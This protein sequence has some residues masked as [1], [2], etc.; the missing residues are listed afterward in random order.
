MP[1]LEKGAPEMLG[2]KRSATIGVTQPS[3]GISTR[4][5]ATYIVSAE[6]KTRSSEIPSGL[7]KSEKQPKLFW[8]VSLFLLL[9]CLPV[10][11]YV[12]SLRLPP[13][14][15][16]LLVSAVPCLLIWA[17]SKQVN[18]SA[19]DF[20]LIM[21]VVWASMAISIN[22]GFET[23]IELIGSVVLDTAGS[24]FLA[25]T[26]IS[27]VVRF[28]RMTRM[29]IG[30]V[31]IMA[32]FTAYES[33]TGTNLI[34]KMFQP[35]FN[36]FSYPVMDKRLS[37]FRARGPF[38]HP[39]LFG[40][41]ASTVFSFAM[42]IKSEKYTGFK[43]AFKTAMVGLAVFSSLSTGA[44]L[45]VILQIILLAWDKLTK[46]FAHRWRVFAVLLLCAYIF[47]DA[48]SNRNPFEVFISYLTFNQGNSYNRVLI[49]IYGTAEVWRHPVFGI[50]HGDWVRPYW[51][52]ISFDNFWL[53]RTMR[54]GLP[55]FFFLFSSVVLI[56]WKLAKLKPENDLT[57]QCRKSLLIM[58]AGLCVTMIT[59]DLWNATY[60]MFFFLLGSGD[61]L[62][63]SD[64]KRD[65]D[66]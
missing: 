65:A 3:T 54:Y 19:A 40:F 7:S 43:R 46:S 64:A 16:F 63:E 47:V 20:M 13:Y 56:A 2:K 32:C 50:G 60:A 44:F 26:L 1:P 18:R 31:M 25:K 5:K 62:Q 58:L 17:S 66:V 30:L 8:P 27:D 59:V 15:M 55:A 52:G 14:R 23:S 12:G 53:L 29:L 41:F 61:W 48:F 22:Q 24:Y 57:A 11:F 38:E 10:Y 6:E 28:Q 42:V 33:V 21:Y 34:T 39:I 35:L 45:S 9:L 49:W 36:I 37:L 51:M 4:I